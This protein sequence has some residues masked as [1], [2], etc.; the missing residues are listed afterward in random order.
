MVICACRA[1]LARAIEKW[2][3]PTQV[4]EEL[5]YAI[6]PRKGRQNTAPDSKPAAATAEALSH[7]PSVAASLDEDHVESLTTKIFVKPSSGKASVA[8][9]RSRQHS[10]DSV[11]QQNRGEVPRPAHLK[12]REKQPIVNSR[13][14]VMF[15]SKEPRV[16]SM[17]QEIDDW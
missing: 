2:G 10:A 7:Q 3:G 17:R 1:D 15:R 6:P 16:P 11:L 4:A 12:A 14:R 8:S 9:L 13:R 5:A